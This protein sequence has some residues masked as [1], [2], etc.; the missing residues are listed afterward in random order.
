VIAFIEIEKR[1]VLEELASVGLAGAGYRYCAFAGVPGYSLGVGVLSRYRIDRATAHSSNVAGAVIPRPVTE[2]VISP[3]GTP[4]SLFI[5]HWKSK[6]GG[7]ETESARIAAARVILRRQSEILAERPDEP[8]IITGDLNENYDEFERTGG[9]AVCALMPDSAD[10]ARAA[11][12][13]EHARFLI[14]SHTKPPASIHFTEAEGVFYSPWGM[15][16]TGGSYFYGAS[17][18]TIDH[19]LLNRNV[20]T[21][22]G[23]T[24][25]NWRYKM[26]TVGTRA[27][28]TSAKG[29]PAAYNP[30]TGQGLS[31]HLP[32]FLTLSRARSRP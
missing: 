20:F 19:M 13:A 7:R 1:T 4:L 9:T 18:E 5:C 8:I 15:E 17:W 6:R 29:T 21:D 25:Q 30:R 11:L 32:L 31:D 3:G 12:D 16:L 10:A 14:I 24:A 26:C 27:P 22:S 23:G 2:I 28:F